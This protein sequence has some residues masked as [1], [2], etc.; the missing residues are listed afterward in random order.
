MEPTKKDSPWLKKNTS[1]SKSP[2]DKNEESVQEKEQ[3]REED[4][5]NVAGIRG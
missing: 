2:E 3:E 5:T 4:N 1:V